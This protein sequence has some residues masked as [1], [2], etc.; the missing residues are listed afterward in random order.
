MFF[1]TETPQTEIWNQL[2]YLKSQKNVENL[3][4][5]KIQSERVQIHHDPDEVHERSFEIVSCIRQ[6]DEYY[7][8]AETV[9]SATQPLLQFYGAHVLVK[10]VILANTT[11]RLSDFEYHGLNGKISTAKPEFRNDLRDYK[12]DQSQWEIEKEF[13]ITNGGVFE[14]LCESINESIPE[15]GEIFTFKDVVSRIPDL[16]EIYRR[17]YDEPSCCSKISHGAQAP[18]LQKG[19]VAGTYNVTPLDCG[20]YKTFT[21]IFAGLFILSNVVR[22]KPAFWMREIEGK[23]SGSASIVEAFCNLAKRR[24]PNDT[25]GSIWNE[26]FEYGTPGRMVG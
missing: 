9:G 4:L 21:M 24:L 15:R 22:Y 14:G 1:W 6:A 20:I 7:R 10:A 18:N 25:L 12:E 13:A 11:K 2:R 8:A 17:H 5:G 3:L 26:D 23:D 16:S 19:T